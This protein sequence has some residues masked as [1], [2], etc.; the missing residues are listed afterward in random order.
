MRLIRHH[1]A[2]WAVASNQLGVMGF[3]AGGH[4][5]TNLAIHNDTGN[6]DADDAIDH[7]SCHPNF[8]MPVYVSLKGLDV[9]ADITANAPPAFLV[10]ATDD[11]TTPPENSLRLYSAL[12]KHNI[13]AELHLSERGSHGF[14]LAKT[15]GPAASWTIL[16]EAWLHQRKL[17]RLAK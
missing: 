2:D 14:G 1:T 4:L 17:L 8:M 16:C 6:P 11:T 9:E 12:V 13:S 3:S 10:G 5:I 7:Q 15:K